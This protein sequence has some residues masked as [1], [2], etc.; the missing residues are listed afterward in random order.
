M[1]RVIITGGAGFIGSNLAAMLLSQGNEV[2]VVDNL[3]TGLMK[4]IA[5]FQNHPHF[6]FSEASIESW[7]DIEKAV[8]WSD[9]IYHLAA[10]VGQKY[11]IANPE[12]TL[13]NNIGGFEAILNALGKTK[14]KA[15][16]LIVSTSEVYC[17]SQE[18]E[19]GT[20][21]ETAD[22]VFFSGQYIQETYPLAKF[23]NEVMG[24]T[25]TAALGGHCT[26]ARVFNTIGVNQR[27]TYGM[28]VP[29]FIEQALSGK[30]L[31]IFGDG[32][33]SRSFSDVRDTC[34]ALNLLLEADESKGQ[35][36]NVGDDRECKIIEL[37]HLI[38][39]ITGSS[40]EIRYLTYQ[41]A[42]GIDNFDDVRRRRPNLTKLKAL[43]G[44][45][46]EYSLE[47]TIHEILKNS[48]QR[49]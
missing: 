27:S 34:R 48:P 23:V 42:Y 47:D 12:S 36:V 32:E 8:S 26:I 18:D 5:P 39:K 4:N 19:D 14:S 38:K 33:Q 1:S 40:S 2:W 37:A 16:V 9:R 35:I 29:T 11:V 6:Q 41:E 7:K 20:V 22:V 21:A 30:P 3:Q 24:L 13:S 25:H 43:T 15:R 44:F 31:T 49:Q 10:N 46:H 45:E 28:V 17:H